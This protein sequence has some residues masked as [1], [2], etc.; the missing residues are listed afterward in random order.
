GTS[1][2]EMSHRGKHYSRVRDEAEADLRTLLAVPDDFE[3]LFMQGGASA[4]NAIVPL[5]LIGRAGSGRADYVLSGHWS[6]KSFNEAAR[7]GDIAVAATAESGTVLDGRSYDPWCWLPDQADWRVRPDA[8]YL[9]LCA[10]E[11]TGG[12]EQAVMPDMADPG[13]HDEPLASE[14]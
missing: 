9:H 1:I 13:L 5:N 11:T 12:V 2:M 3:V 14:P 4:Q 8:A 10:N 7:Y 6:R